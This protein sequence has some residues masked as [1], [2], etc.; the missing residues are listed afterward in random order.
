MT[1]I[2][3]P[4][5]TV[6]CDA[7]F[8]GW[9][10]KNVLSPKMDLD[11]WEKEDSSFT[12]P[13]VAFKDLWRELLKKEKPCFSLFHVSLLNRGG[14][15]YF[16]LF[17]SRLSDDQ[18]MLT[19]FLNEEVLSRHKR[20]SLRKRDVGDTLLKD[21]SSLLLLFFIFC[22]TFV[23]DLEGFDSVVSSTEK[24]SH[25]TTSR[26]KA[27][28]RRPPSQS[29]TSVSVSHF[30]APEKHERLETPAKDSSGVADLRTRWGREAMRYTADQKWF[31]SPLDSSSIS[32]YLLFVYYQ[33]GGHSLFPLSF[34]LLPAW[35]LLDPEV[36]WMRKKWHLLWWKTRA[37]L[38]WPINKTKFG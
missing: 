12:P 14:S 25:P 23:L 8:G 5:D 13:F 34:S 27:T 33:P 11:L 6:P 18:R 32:F 2:P 35:F 1:S 4:M 36:M 22:F 30:S 37:R 15:D 3:L 19:A 21:P 26:P 29:L 9:D 38:V 16:I 28:G 20:W 7:C 10:C 31:E 24:L 17:E